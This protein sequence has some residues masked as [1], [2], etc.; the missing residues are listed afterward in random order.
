MLNKKIKIW[1]LKL[2]KIRINFAAVDLFPFIHR[3][4]FF[5]EM[6]CFN[7][8]FF[9]KALDALVQQ[10]CDQ[11][12][13]GSHLM[14]ERGR[15]DKLQKLLLARFT[16]ILL[17]DILPVEQK[18]TWRVVDV[19]RASQLLINFVGI[20]Q[21]QSE[22][23]MR[24]DQSPLQPL[25][26]LGTN[27]TITKSNCQICLNLPFHKKGNGR[28]LMPGHMPPELP[29]RGNFIS[30]DNMV[31]ED[32]LSISFLFNFFRRQGLQLAVRRRFIP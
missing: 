6:D 9:I 31:A 10:L 29:H 18:N 30:C 11:L 3:F 14:E 27:V 25:F 28:E 19:E 5:K 13:L 8:L 4:D 12:F 7:P 23:A 32:L 22:L 26:H 20:D 15:S 24:L 16:S 1:F 2:T 17:S 21:G